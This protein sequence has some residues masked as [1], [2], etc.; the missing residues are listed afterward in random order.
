MLFLRSYNRYESQ[1]VKLIYYLIANNIN[2]MSF[3]M[4]FG[5]R[6]IGIIFNGHCMAKTMIDN[7]TILNRL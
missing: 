3:T 1:M 7:L 4:S 2:P 6:T 5:E